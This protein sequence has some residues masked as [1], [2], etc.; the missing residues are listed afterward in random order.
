MKKYKGIKIALIV[1][2]ALLVV[3]LAGAWSMFG[4]QLMAANTIQKLDEGL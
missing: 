4:T 1:V 3:L 2:A